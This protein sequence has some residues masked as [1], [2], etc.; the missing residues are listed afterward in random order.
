MGENTQTMFT[1]FYEQLKKTLLSN[2]D[3]FCFY[4]YFEPNTK[5]NNRAML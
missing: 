4:T 5:Y 3:V 2:F 1:V